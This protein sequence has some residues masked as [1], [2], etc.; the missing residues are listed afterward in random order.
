MPN[1]AI[2]IM[3]IVSV[4]RM[5]LIL[6]VSIIKESTALTDKKRKKQKMNLNF[7][8]GVF[9]FRYNKILLPATINSTMKKTIISSL[10]IVTFKY[11]YKSF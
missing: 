4:D 8:R 7:F 3:S 6:T 5:T 9:S 10:K 1:A 11:L 2:N